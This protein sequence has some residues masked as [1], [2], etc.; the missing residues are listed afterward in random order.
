MTTLYKTAV[1][2][3]S[4]AYAGISANSRDEMQQINVEFEK[5]SHQELL[6]LGAN[7]A[8]STEFVGSR[9]VKNGNIEVTILGKAKKKVDIYN[10]PTPLPAFTVWELKD[11]RSNHPTKPEV[12][13]W[14]ELSRIAIKAEDI[15]N[16]LTNQSKEEKS[17]MSEALKALG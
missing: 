15:D 12:T 13:K 16:A 4:N 14:M 6:K 10:L 1:T 17:F 11:R 8:T 5:E 7:M 2:L 9:Y 3:T